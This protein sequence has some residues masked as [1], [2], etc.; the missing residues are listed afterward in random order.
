MLEHWTE[1]QK[2]PGSNPD[3]DIFFL[4]FVSNVL[5]KLSDAIFVCDVS[6]VIYVCD[7]ICM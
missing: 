5:K 3:V 4:S 2:V 6:D 1:D 7:V